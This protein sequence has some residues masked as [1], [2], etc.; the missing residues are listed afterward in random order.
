MLVLP[1]SLERRRKPLTLGLLFLVVAL[2]WA[3]VFQAPDQNLHIW[4]LDV[5][6]GDAILIQTP[7]NQKILIDGG[8]N[9]SVLPRLGE[10]L[11]F[12]ERTLD[13]V[14]LSHPDADHVTGLVSVLKNYQVGQ[15]LT[16]SYSCETKVCQEFEGLVTEKGVPRW[17]ARAGGKVS[18][19]D[20]EMKIYWPGGSCH[21]SRNDCSIVAL[22]DFYDFEALFPGDIEE[23][24]QRALSSAGF[25]VSKVELLKVPH[26]GANCLW[27]PFLEVVSPEVSIISVGKNSYGHPTVVTLDKLQKIGSKVFRTD[28][29]GTVGVISDGESWWVR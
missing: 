26:H 18:L 29:R 5:G 25:S 27:E 9:E 1:D 14:V 10:V 7:A 24:G 19:G 8:P 15:L 23:G 20:L 21:L 2:V 4:V 17:V 11:P 13:L 12:W 3:A 6:Q 16:G 22:L 28:E